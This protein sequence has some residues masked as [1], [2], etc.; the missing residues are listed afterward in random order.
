[1]NTLNKNKKIGIK[2]GHRG[3]SIG[4]VGLPNVGKSTL[5]NALTNVAVPAE[6]YPFCTIE[7]NIGIVKVSDNRLNKISEI[8][9]PKE[10]VPAVIKFVD[11]A[12]LVEGASKGEGLGNKFLANIR[13]VD[14]IVH[15]VRFFKDD[16][17]IH[18]SNRINPGDDIET[19][20]TELGL[21]DLETI[22]KRLLS[23]RKTIRTVKKD[24]LVH[25]E[26]RLLEKMQVAIEDGACARDLE[27]SE[28]EIKIIRELGLLSLKPIVY[29]F[30]TKDLLVDID[31]MKLQAGVGETEVAIKM[32]VKLESELTEMGSEEQK[33]FMK[34][35][36][37]DETGLEKLSQV[38]YNLLGLQSFFTAGEKEVKAWTINVGETAPEA[39][40]RIHGD[41]ESKFICAEV[42][43]YN[44]FINCKGWAEARNQGKVRLEGKSYV[45]S[46]GD[47]I[48]FRHGA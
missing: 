23:I 18:V 2:K 31:E 44:D 16:N 46:D 3:M 4:I 37:V 35:F 36:G 17:V 6:N 48:V 11:I 28:D 27:Y 47:V 7:P 8:V 24:D 41:F 12:G 20:E 13:E 40:G 30:N 42:V 1:M 26:N 43:S 39:A 14:A 32:D 29:L 19:I 5:F 38:C 25:I 10:I 33:L 21:K 45:M 9:N 22:E 15:V 34:E